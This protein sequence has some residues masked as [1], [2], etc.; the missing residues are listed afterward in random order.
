MVRY[1]TAEAHASTNEAL[2]RAVFSELRERVPAGLRYATYKLAD[3]IT[4][5]HL[6]TIDTPNENP[7]TSLPSF[8]SFQRALSERCVEPPVVTELCPLESYG[9][10]A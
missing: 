10:G 1:K 3:G 4:F 8:K 6:A 9:A 5:I 2:V 7:L